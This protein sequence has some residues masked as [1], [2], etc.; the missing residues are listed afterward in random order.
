MAV[1]LLCAPALEADW[2]FAMLGDTRGEK[3]TT[4]NGVST[5]LRTIAEKIAT[6]NPELVLVAGDL[7]NGNDTNT[8]SHVS[9]A[10][11]YASWKAAM[12]P[13]FNYD[14][15][16]GIPIYPV[17][18]NHDNN[19]SEG[20]VIPELK[21]AY[22]DAFSPYVPA[23]GPNNGPSD[24]QRGFSWSF[25]H[26]NVTFVGAD[27]YFY[28]NQTPG[29]NGYHSMDLTWI[30]QQFQDATSAYE[31]FMAHVPI[32]MTQGQH[33]PEHFFGD[34]PAG[35]ATR[36]NFWNALGANGVQLYLTGHLHNETVAS[37]TN[38]YGNTIIQ[39]LA[40]N[41]G[42][43]LGAVV[44]DPDPGVTVLYTNALFGFSLATVS[45]QSMKIEYYSLHTGDNSWSKDSY[46]TLILPNQVVPEPSTAVLLAPAMM[47][48]MA[49]RFRKRR[50]S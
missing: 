33:T 49:V 11:Q 10:Q 46:F 5:H 22:Y 3:S 35:F 18:G 31:V 2:S 12:A 44:L 25:T 17:R 29:L 34:N 30:N 21:Q 16:T 27:Q 36:S 45:D 4:T 42:A 19:D 38:D 8:S 23:N 1:S 39:L 15:G 41:G 40:G 37:T 28:Y 6:L 26:N 50:R 20:P 14:T 48:L 32:F 43:P 7:V 24:D 9:F 47:V 13:V